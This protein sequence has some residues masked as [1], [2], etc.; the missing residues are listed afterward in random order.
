MGLEQKFS[1]F[2]YKYSEPNEPVVADKKGEDSNELAA[3]DKKGDLNLPSLDEIA[4]APSFKS[5]LD[6]DHWVEQKKKTPQGCR[7]L[8]NFNSLVERTAGG[9]SAGVFAYLKMI[10]EKNKNLPKEKRIEP[11]YDPLERLNS[12]DPTKYREDQVVSSLDIEDFSDILKPLNPEMRKFIFANRDHL[13]LS[14]VK[15]IL[16]YRL[17]D[18]VIAYHVSPTDINLKDTLKGDVYFSTDIKQL[19]KAPG[20]RYLYAF[21]L[22]AQLVETTKYGAK[23]CFGCLKA[24]GSGVGIMDKIEI[25]DYE[26]PEKAGNQKEIL[27]S[28]GASFSDYIPASQRAN[29]FLDNYQSHLN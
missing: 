22:P 14:R 11:I 12:L 29:D 4:A 6:F 24:S 20:A 9:D 2:K 19:F 21:R 15:E 3:A 8:D 16:N 23:D 25:Y 17:V 27:D 1:N 26:H 5:R 13:T 10:E 18:S 28:L 7:E